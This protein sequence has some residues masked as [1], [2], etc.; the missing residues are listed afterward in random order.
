MS[1]GLAPALAARRADLADRACTPPG[2]RRRRLAPHDAGCWSAAQVAL[3]VTL[4]VVAGL[5]TRTLIALERLEPGFDI[6]N[7][8]TAVVTLPEA[9]PPDA[10]ARW[11]DEAVDARAPAAGRHR[12]PA[13]PAGCR[14]P[15][16]AGIPNRG[17]E[18]E[19]Q[20]ADA[21]ARGR[22]AVDYVDHAGAARDARACRSSKGARSPTPTAPDAP[23]VAIVNQAMAR[24]FW[25][26]RSPLGARLRQGDDPPGQW[27]TVVGIVGDIRN[28]DADQPPLP[29]LYVPL[30]QQPART[31]TLTLRTAGDPAALAEPLRRAIASFD[32]DQPLYDVRTMRRGVGGRPARLAD[33]DSGD[34]RARARSRSGWPGLGVW[35]VAAQSV[36]QRTREIGVRVALGASAAAGRRG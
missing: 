32:P 29:Y 3:A 14:L 4:L 36:G 27:R 34:G 26:G 22:W 18:I 13:R 28:D 9:M 33:A 21:D 2:A 25:P 6:D 16:A 24:R 12:R 19:G 8:L 1:A 10:A 17:L 11:I 23:L 35:G 7:V 31:M 30:A 20:P 15:A 5:A